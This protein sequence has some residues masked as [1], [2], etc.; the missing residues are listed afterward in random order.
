L[1]F[2]WIGDYAL[3]GL[4]ER[5]ELSNAVLGEIGEF[6]EMPAAMPER[7]AAFVASLQDLPVYAAIQVRSRVAAALALGLLREI[8]EREAADLARWGTAPPYRGT[9]ITTVTAREGRA[10]LTLYYCLTPDSLVMALNEA[11]LHVAIDGLLDAPPVPAD[12][13]KQD[14]SAAQAVLELAFAPGSP[15]Y[16]S[17]AWGATAAL[18]DDLNDAPSLAEAVLRGDPGV[19]SEPARARAAYRAVYGVVPVT[20]E[21]QDFTLGAEGISFPP[22]GTVN[23][24]IWPDLPVPG[25]PLDRVLSRLA[26]LR[27]ALSFDVEPWSPPGRP[28][29]SLHARAMVE[30]R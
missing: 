14:A 26:R 10:T 18:L 20:L 27:T 19:R 23:A 16:K 25:S 1:S 21:G 29:Q 11:A 7:R 17:L 22:R 24:P 6:I 3:I 15:L 9:Q 5:N 28:L 13:A 2:D 4:A 8:G 30:E 12:G